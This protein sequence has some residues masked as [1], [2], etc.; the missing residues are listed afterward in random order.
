MANFD[1]VKWEIDFTKE[2]CFVCVS[3]EYVLTQICWF[4]L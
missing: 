3:Y 1:A 2:T 4:K